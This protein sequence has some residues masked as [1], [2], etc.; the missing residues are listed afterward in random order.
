M[1]DYRN[2]AADLVA[3]LKKQGAD[4]SDVYIVA[5]SRF[6]VAL[7][8]GRIEKLEQAISKGLGLRV[9]KGGATALTF[10]TDFADRTIKD[11]IKETMEIVK[12]SNADKYNGLAPKELLGAYDGKLM[13]FDEALPG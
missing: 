8:L 12:V 6:N 11:L 10:T 9:F 5:T 3:A 7:R 1:Q 4:A 13:M 2:L